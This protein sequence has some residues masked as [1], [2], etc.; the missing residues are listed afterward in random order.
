MISSIFLS[1]F[2]K[3]FALSSEDNSWTQPTQNF[4]LFL[5]VFSLMTPAIKLGILVP[6]FLIFTHFNSFAQ[7]VSQLEF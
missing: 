7:T 3:N 6:A 5:S 2:A 1:S 4:V